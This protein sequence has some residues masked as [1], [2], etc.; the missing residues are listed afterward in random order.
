MAT[1]QKWR[2][3][4][5]MTTNFNTAIAFRIGKLFNVFHKVMA[6]LIMITNESLKDSLL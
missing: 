5:M 3:T 4:E 1:N 6:L 2:Q